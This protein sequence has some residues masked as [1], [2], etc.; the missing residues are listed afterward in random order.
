MAR[1]KNG[2]NDLY[3]YCINNDLQY[4]LEEWDYQNNHG[5]TPSDYSFG[6]KQEVFWIC[7]Y[8]GSSFPSRINTRV[9]YRTQSCTECAK[10]QS[11]KTRHEKLICEKNLATEFPNISA[12]WDYELNTGITP[13]DVTKGT[14]DVYYWKCPNG[15]PSYPARVANRAIN[16]TGCPV[17]SGRKLLAG[18][19][20][21]AT[22]NPRLASQ[23]DYEK[24]YPKTPQEVFPRSGKKYWWICPL[25][26]ESY[27]AIV[28][29][30]AAGKAHDKCSK[31]GSSFPEQAIYY[32]VKKIFSDAV[33]RDTSF[34]YELDVYIP[35]INVAV[36]YDGVKYHEGQE[37]LERDNKKDALCENADVKLFRF[38]DPVLPDTNSA[39]RITCPDKRESVG[40]GIRELLAQLSPESKIAVDPQ[41]EYY[42]ILDNTLLVQKEK[43]IVVTHPKIAE[44]WHPTMNLP[45]TR[46]KVTSGMSVDV[47]WVCPACEKPYLAKMYSRK[48]GRGCP[49]C[50]RKSSAKN[51][52][53]TAAKKNNF[54]LQYRELAKEIFIEDNPGL[55]ISN[56][57]AGSGGEIIW[58]CRQCGKPF[59]AS[60]KHRA[61]GTGCPVCG[62]ERT[63]KA[64]ERAV[65]NLDTGERFESLTKAAESVGGDKRNIHACCS[66]RTKKA[67][68][69]R[70][71][72]ADDKTRKRPI[73]MIIHN[74]ETNEL[75]STIQEAANKYGCN[76]SSISSALNGK[77][78]TSMGYHWE[79]VEKT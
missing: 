22:V 66:G 6:S 49:D 3:S 4:L 10:K 38:R 57:A 13:E 53:L 70:W 64:A 48:A 56:L 60:I 65:I 11:W 75:F 33:S 20:D 17:C 15:H 69:Y 76:R 55:D 1:L 35:S 8:C 52:S 59:P 58:R 16:G 50:G 37:K 7:R 29:N 72:Y 39:I 46:E 18:I 54:L 79:F 32:Y 74:I 2:I 28:S 27:Q 9:R 19:N 71:Q 34:G 73:G 42:E 47:W 78:K 30:R 31:K 5:K 21:L 14:R 44:E 43:S 24:N 40:E 61:E 68:G 62:R 51:R 23:W 45:L 41:K 63:R 77:T 67:Y 26:G 36:E 25:C 12:E